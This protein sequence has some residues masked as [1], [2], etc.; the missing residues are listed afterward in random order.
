MLNSKKT[1]QSKDST[2][3]ITKTIKNNYNN[4]KLTNI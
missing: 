3:T 2:V 1:D 4:E